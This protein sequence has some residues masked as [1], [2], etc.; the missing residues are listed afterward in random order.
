MP[1]I[2]L[3]FS[4][5]DIVQSADSQSSPIW[6]PFPRVEIT[7]GDTL[8]FTY[9]DYVSGADEFWIQIGDADR[10]EGNGILTYA[11]TPEEAGTSVSVEIR[12]VESADR[13]YTDATLTFQ[14]V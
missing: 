9:K 11:T 14:I 2:P 6:Y 5:T 3:N 1:N 8:T 12:A 4:V 7:A 10:E 13:I